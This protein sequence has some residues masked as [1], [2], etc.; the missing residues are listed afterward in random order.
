MHRKGVPATLSVAVLAALV[1]ASSCGVEQ[2]EEGHAMHAEQAAH[3]DSEAKSGGPLADVEMVVVYD[4]RPY[5]QGLTPAWGFACLLR[6]AEKTI[7]FDTGGDG[8]ILLENMRDLDVDPGEIELIV[9]SHIHGDHTGG[10]PLLL[11]EK[12]D[13][14]VY[15]PR[16][17]PSR[18]KESAR[19]RGA[20]TVDVDEHTE[21][22]ANV[23]TTGELGTRVKEQ[24][25]IVTT[26]RGLIVITGCAHPGI[27]EMVRHAKDLFEEEVLFVVGGFHL[28]PVGRDEIE[29]IIA[30]FR[31]LGVEYVAPCHCSG[32]VAR[33]LFREEYGDHFIDIGVGKTIR[34]ADLSRE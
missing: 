27:V 7:L 14:T 18:L 6:G 29:E 12:G 26:E 31:E 24:A 23:H 1:M 22:C 19:A 5:L 2:R 17:F 32:D 3:T 33:D 9:L 8:S 16:S 21:I 25:L 30:T 28:E 13:V 10:L 20:E 34:L 15:L 4:N 11:E